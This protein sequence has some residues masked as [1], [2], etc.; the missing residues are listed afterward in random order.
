MLEY[1]LVAH[2]VLNR[3]IDLNDYAF[4]SDESHPGGPK[5]TYKRTDGSRAV[6]YEAAWNKSFSISNEQFYGMRD[7]KRKCI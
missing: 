6:L 1:P 3:C 4:L 5:I 7:D 2:L